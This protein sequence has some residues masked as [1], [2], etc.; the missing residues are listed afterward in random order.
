MSLVSYNTD[1]ASVQIFRN[2]RRQLAP[3]PFGH[4]VAIVALVI[5]LCTWALR[6][7]MRWRQL[8]RLQRALARRMVRR[9]L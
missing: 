7:I 1:T 2:V 5:A 3:T 6:A 8:R 9:I 4:Y